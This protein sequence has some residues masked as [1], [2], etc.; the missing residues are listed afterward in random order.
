MAHPRRLRFAVELHGPLEGRTWADSVRWIEDAG[1]ST[2]FV[3]DHFNEGLG[4]IAAMATAA[5]ASGELLVGSLVF[6]ADYRHPVVLAREIATIDQL[7]E[8][9]VELGIGAGWKAEDY[10]ASGISMDP[11]KVRVD[12]MIEAVTVLKGLFAPGPFSFQG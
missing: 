3:P 8:G 5:E 1:Y 12:R 7:S 11:P 9:R 4:P 2:L 10:T 6:A